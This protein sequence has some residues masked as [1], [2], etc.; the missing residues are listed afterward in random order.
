M[1]Q[2]LWQSHKP[3]NRAP[4][5]SSAKKHQLPRLSPRPLPR[6]VRHKPMR[7]RP[8]RVASVDLF[9]SVIVSV[10]GRLPATRTSSRIWRTKAQGLD[11]CLSVRRG[12]GA[13]QVRNY[14]FLNCLA[15][16]LFS[17]IQRLR[18]GQKAIPATAN[19]GKIA[20]FPWGIRGS[21]L[22]QS[23]QRVV[24]PTPVLR[25]SVNEILKHTAELLYFWSVQW[26]SSFASKQTPIN[27][28]V[29]FQEETLLF[30]VYFLH[31]CPL[32]SLKNAAITW[33]KHCLW[34][35]M[36]WDVSISQS[37]VQ[38]ISQSINQS[39]NQ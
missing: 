38:S 9:C 10:R 18:F 28:T 34:A 5:V 23:D 37:D 33:T 29:C 6:N 11:L 25:G 27:F 31:T 2:Y 26:Q 36:L 32:I 21:N 17:W 16:D 12:R 30:L 24:A 1:A 3:L 20:C 35:C 14:S 15:M 4:D 13:E 22:L 39:T 19:L 7:R 8:Q